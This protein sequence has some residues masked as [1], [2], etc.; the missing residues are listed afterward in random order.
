MATT[1]A[2]EDVSQIWEA[3]KAD[4]TNQELRNKLVD[5]KQYIE[6]R[7]DDLPEIRDWTWPY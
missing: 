4:P 7:G 5:H 6:E 1:L 3:F 2:A